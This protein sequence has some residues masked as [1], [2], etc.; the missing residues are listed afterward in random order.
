MNMMRRDALRDSS[1]HQY[2]AE[3]CVHEDDVRSATSDICAFAYM[4]TDI[5]GGEGNCVVSAVTKKRDGGVRRGGAVV[6]QVWAGLPIL[7][8]QQDGNIV[9][10]RG[11]DF[12]GILPIS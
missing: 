1:M 4:S 11:L 2:A 7:P 9:E 12:L 3:I 5:S 6:V 8:L 10:A